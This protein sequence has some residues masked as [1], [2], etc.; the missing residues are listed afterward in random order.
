MPLLKE[1]REG[2]IRQVTKMNQQL[3]E[4][5]MY[6]GVPDMKSF[7]PSVIHIPAAYQF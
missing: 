7:D 1:G 3:S 6:T 4:L 5:C 2:V